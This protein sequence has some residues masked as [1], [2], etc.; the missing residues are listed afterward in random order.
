MDEIA[1]QI[2]ELVEERDPDNPLQYVKQIVQEM[3]CNKIK[4]HI[5]NCKDCDMHCDFRE[6]PHGNPNASLMIIGSS[7]EDA[8]TEN[9]L[10]LNYGES[11]RVLDIILDSLNV[12]KEEVFYASCMA[13]SPQ[14]NLSGKLIKRMPN[15]SEVKNCQVFIKSL[16]DVVDPLVI[17]LMGP[18][19]YNT[20]NK[21]GTLIANRGE[22]FEYNDIPVIPT[23]APSYFATAPVDEITLD[24]QKS[25]FINDIEAAVNHIRENYPNIN[26]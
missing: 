8:L 3:S 19:A 16:I 7:P 22:W 12:N 10:A 11:K 21:E 13:C 6:L 18:L 23:Y 1:K 17:I 9:Q 15:T 4:K 5:M 2:L 26:L 14:K 24:G 25:D 20:F